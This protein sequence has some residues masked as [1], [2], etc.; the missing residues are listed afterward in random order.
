M[1][2]LIDIAVPAINFI[3]LVAVGMDL[4][5]HDVAGVRQQRGLVLAGLF[6]PVVLLPA[7]AVGLASLFQTDRDVAGGLLLIAACPIGSISNA[8]SYL[9]RASSALAV[10]LTALS[11]LCAGVTI[12]LVR[13]GLE[14]ALG[15]PLDFAAPLPFLAQLLVLLV[16]PVAIGMWLRHR[17]PDLA[18][19]CGPVLRPVAFIGVSTLFALII[20]E[21]PGAFLSGLATTVPVAAVFV[22]ISVAAGWLTAALLTQDPRD[23]F[24]I[25]AEFGTRNIAVAV[26][27]AVTLLGR[28]E[29]ARFAAIY[30]I[31]ETPLMLAAVALFRRSHPHPQFDV[32]RAD[33]L[34]A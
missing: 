8:Y 9:A 25:A 15:R 17:S 30:A 13:G 1:Q 31:T 11:S 5:A 22:V 19:R 18:E 26:A 21:N 24:T 33:R 29:F 12:P 7:I 23:R 28:V 4:T 10:S 34:G 6:A 2:A 32:R 16:L 20:G 3:L 14:L 27:I